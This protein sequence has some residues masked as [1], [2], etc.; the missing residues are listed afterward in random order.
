MKKPDV[1]TVLVTRP[2]HQA[3]QFSKK[4]AALGATVIN[5]PAIDIVFRSAPLDP[6]E[7]QQLESSTLWIFTSA[8]AVSGA[9]KLGAVPKKSATIAAIGRA[10]ARSL[11]QHGIAAQLVPSE[12]NSEGLLTLLQDQ[13]ENHRVTIVRG[14]L[15][16]ETLQQ[17]LEHLGHTVNTLDVYQRL[18]PAVDPDTLQNAIDALPCTISIT[19]NLG[20]E[21][22]RQIIPDAHHPRLF[23]SLLIVNSSR[24]TDLAVRLGF[25]GTVRVASPPGD[26]GQ[27]QV[28]AQ[29]PN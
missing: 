3:T 12:H 10:T 23:Q 20:L 18:L 22:L 1:Q 21:H 29:L 25:S 5:L 26:E 13:N 28:F 14:G 7:R 6:A 9:I 8:N 27:L 11:K 15:G 19:S 17:G 4:L 2:A 16:R 24:C